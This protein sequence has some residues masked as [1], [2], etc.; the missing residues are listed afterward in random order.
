VQFAASDKPSQITGSLP[1]GGAVL[2]GRR[3][4][5]WFVA[6]SVRIGWLLMMV[7]VGG[8]VLYNLIE[9]SMQ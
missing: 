6:G 2:I 4:G 9:R 8:F 7:L 5:N 1:I 3:F